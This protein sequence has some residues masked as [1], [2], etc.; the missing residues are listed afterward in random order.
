M[1]FQT[2]DSDMKEWDELKLEDVVE[3]K[4][5]TLNLKQIAL[6]LMHA[7]YQA[8]KG[9]ERVTALYQY[10]SWGMCKNIIVEEIF[11]V[12]PEELKGIDLFME[13]WITFLKDTQGDLAGELLTMACKYQGGLSRLYETAREASSMHPVLF[14]RAC[15]SLLDEKM[16]VPLHKELLELYKHYLIVGG[17]PM[18]V[19]EYVK[20]VKLLGSTDIQNEIL[21]NYIADMAKYSSPSESVKIRSCYNSIPNQLAKDNKKF[22]Y[23]VV[24]SGGNATIFGAAIEWLNFAGIIYKCQKVTSAEV[25]IAVH[26]DISSFKIYMSDVGM[27]T[28]KSGILQSMILST[29]EIDN[30]FIGAI[31]ENYVASSLASNGHPQYYWESSNTAKIDFLLQNEHGV[32][33]VEVKAGIHTK[34][35]SLSVYMTKYKPEFAIKISAKNFGF[36]NGIKSVPLY[37]VFC[38]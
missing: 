27:L 30:S 3:Q 25:P 20:T 35:R 15:K 22:Q 4:L 36:E 34:S 8:T 16:P 32:I 6:N 29:L 9:V 5:V 23:K 21:N 26:S 33:P 19:N 17:M 37:A 1:A 13:D 7:K 12:G 10:L 38:I 24:Q 18:V 14:E 31:A 2:F 28:M 11:T